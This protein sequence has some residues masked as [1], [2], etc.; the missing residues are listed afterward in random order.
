MIGITLS[1]DHNLSYLKTI[2][3]EGKLNYQLNLQSYSQMATR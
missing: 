2:I 3:W 1:V